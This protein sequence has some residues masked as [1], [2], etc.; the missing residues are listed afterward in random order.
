MHTFVG[1]A[2]N[3]WEDLL[4]WGGYAVIMQLMIGVAGSW[5]CVSVSLVEGCVPCIGGLSLPDENIEP[6]LWFK[7]HP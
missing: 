3:V 1:G 4:S 6:A 5:K 2:R 7:V